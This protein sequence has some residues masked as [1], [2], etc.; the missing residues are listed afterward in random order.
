MITRE[1]LLIL[2]EG[3]TPIFKEAYETGKVNVGARLTIRKPVR[4]PTKTESFQS[5]EEREIVITQD[6]GFL[7]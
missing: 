2:E 4:F 6:I 3:L 1:A 7:F 5:E